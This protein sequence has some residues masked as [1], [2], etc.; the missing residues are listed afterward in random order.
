[1]TLSA[2]TIYR[3]SLFAPP[4]RPTKKKK[5][6]AQFTSYKGTPHNFSTNPKPPH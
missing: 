5:K 4:P 3:A 1:M 2:K 6:K